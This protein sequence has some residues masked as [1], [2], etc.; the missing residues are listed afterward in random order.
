MQVMQKKAP[1][2][3]VSWLKCNAEYPTIRVVSHDEKGKM[4]MLPQTSGRNCA[5]VTSARQVKPVLCPP[6]ISGFRKVYS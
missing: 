3:A 2:S 4:G 1:V 6:G 5:R